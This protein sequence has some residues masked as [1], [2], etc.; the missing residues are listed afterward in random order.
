MGITLFGLQISKKLRKD[1]LM[2][3]QEN[4]ATRMK[5][6]KRGNMK[7]VQRESRIAR[8]GRRETHV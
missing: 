4:A 1:V 8:L 7:P 2:T 5:T 3:R 6:R